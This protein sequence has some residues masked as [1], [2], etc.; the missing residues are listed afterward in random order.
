M[1]WARDRRQPGP[2]AAPAALWPM[3]GVQVCRGRCGGAAVEGQARRDRYRG[4]GVNVQA[5]WCTCE[6]PSEEPLQ[7]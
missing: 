5:G 6:R 1:R 2:R 7:D 3:P 4:A